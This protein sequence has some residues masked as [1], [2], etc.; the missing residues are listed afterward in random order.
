MFIWS[1]FSQTTVAPWLLCILLHIYRILNSSTFF[2]D[3]A[4]F[5]VKYPASLFHVLFINILN[6]LFCSLTLPQHWELKRQTLKL[7]K[8][9][10]GNNDFLFQPSPK[11]LFSLFLKCR[12]C[13]F[14]KGLDLLLFFEKIFAENCMMGLMIFKGKE[15]WVEWSYIF[16]SI[17]QSTWFDQRS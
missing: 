14:L 12:N 13:L 8:M 7:N 2:L 15:T 11:Y 9:K 5:L 10:H 1:D 4:A 16:W 6:I 3:Q 17:F